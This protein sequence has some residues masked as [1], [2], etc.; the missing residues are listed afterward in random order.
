MALY[1]AFKLMLI[2][3]STSKLLAKEGSALAKT[4]S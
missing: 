3:S 1:P 2:D 4:K